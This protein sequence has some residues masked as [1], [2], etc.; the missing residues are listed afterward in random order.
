M[1]PSEGDASIRRARTARFIHG[2]ELSDR[3]NARALEEFLARGIR[4]AFPLGK[5][6]MISGMPTASA[7]EPLSRKM[8]QEEPSPALA[9]RA[10]FQAR[11]CVSAALPESATSGPEGSRTL[12]VTRS[13]RRV[14]RL[15]REKA[16]TGKTRALRSAQKLSC[17]SN[18]QLLTAPA[19]RLKALLPEIV[20]GGGRTTG[21]YR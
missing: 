1:S 16:R 3:V 10:R 13:G 8:T 11:L 14:A 2:P 18:R 9:V 6:E 21:L 5:G 15:E 7:A 17:Q 20:F 12:P 4:Y 19:A